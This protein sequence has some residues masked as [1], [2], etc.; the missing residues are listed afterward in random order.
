[1]AAPTESLIEKV[2]RENEER[3]VK[4]QEAEKKRL[5]R[6]LNAETRSKDIME[7]T[8][9]KKVQHLI[10]KS[11]EFKEYLEEIG[12]YKLFHWDFPEGGKAGRVWLAKRPKECA[13]VRESIG[14]RPPSGIFRNT[15]DSA[16]DPIHDLICAN[17]DAREF[18]REVQET[19]ETKYGIEM[20]PG[21]AI[22]CIIATQKKH[23]IGFMTAEP[24]NLSWDCNTVCSQYFD[25]AQWLLDGEF[26]LWSE[27]MSRFTSP[28][29][30][31]AFMAWVWSIFMEDDPLRCACHIQ[32]PANAGKSAL[33]R[34]LHNVTKN[35]CLAVN[36]ESFNNQF[37]AA[38]LYTKR[39][40]TW[41]DC[42]Y[43]TYLMNETI[44]SAL[45]G[46]MVDM[47]RKGE[48]SLSAKLHIKL[49]V[50][51]NYPPKID[52][53][54]N[55]R[56]RLLF[57]KVKGRGKDCVIDPTYD[58]KLQQEFPYFLKV[59]K[60]AYADIV[61]DGRMPEE[62][63]HL[64]ECF[65]LEQVIFDDLCLAKFTFQE[66]VSMDRRRAREIF[67]TFLERERLTRGA[68]SNKQV[69]IWNKFEQYLLDHKKISTKSDSLRRVMFHGMCIQ[70]QE[71]AS[72][73]TPVV[74]D[75][76]LI[77]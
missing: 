45:G 2:Q 27:F 61:V 47:E 37:S 49:L 36:G 20:S 1:M 67:N 29:A 31:K 3:L 55:A 46:G 16:E 53:E 48:N 24:K 28:T 41:D 43:F 26:P 39:V 35:F 66:G 33:A 57:I 51:S 60:Q 42:R 74:A 12:A 13:E 11:P 68:S 77:L 56:S 71:A 59:C 18:F 64:H 76:D 23:G 6:E 10:E 9:L 15:S 73:G 7:K 50:M 17:P 63:K 21:E 34:T 25:P 14:Y 22:R 69:L 19:I 30:P 32:G 54:E 65:T 70:G 62:T 58:T 75:E 40:A 72:G 4:A 38:K 8:Q 44:H 52:D 5:E